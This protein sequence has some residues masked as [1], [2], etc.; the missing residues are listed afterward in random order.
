MKFTL[1][2]LF[3]HIDTSCS[4]D[5]IVEKLPTLG[6]EVEDVCDCAKKFAGIFVGR[7]V[8]CKKH[9]NADKLSLC[10]VDV[11]GRNGD[12]L[13]QIVCGATN[14]RCGLTVAVALPGTIIPVTGAKLKSGKIRGIESEAMMCSVYELQMGID[15]DGIIELDDSF[16]IGTPFA[17]AM[18][19]SDIVFDVSITPNRADCCCVRGIARMLAA[20]GLGT[21]KDIKI[22]QC[23]ESEETNVTVNIETEKCHYFSYKA[24]YGIQD[25]KTPGYIARRLSAIGQKVI[26][27]PVDI[28]NY[29]CLD[30]GQPMHMFDLDKL[31]DNFIVRESHNAEEI[32]ALNGCHLTIPDEGII[33]G[34]K[35]DAFSVA[36]IIGGVQTA[37]SDT[38]KNVLIESAHFDRIAISL[39]AQKMRIQTDSSYRN[40]RGVD[41]E[42]VD[43]AMQYAS[44]LLGTCCDCKFGQTKSIGQLPDN[45][46]NIVVHYDRFVK[47][48][49][50]TQKEWQ[51]IAGVVEKLDIKVTEFNDKE[52]HVV[53]PS[54]R[55]DLNIE[56]DIIEE[57]MIMFGYDAIVP[58]DLP[59]TE[60]L[61]DKRCSTDII[62]DT[63][64]ANGVN[65]IKTFSFIDEDTCKIFEPDIAKHVV[66][67][68]PLTNEFAVMRPNLISSILRVLKNN[69]D[70][71][72][73]D[74]RLF[75]IGKRFYKLD[76]EII[77][78]NTLLIV[79]MGSN[80]ERIWSE[81]QR[82]VDVFDIKSIVERL[83]SALNIQNY[84]IE[85]GGAQHFHPG[86]VGK[87]VIRRNDCLVEFGELH[88]EI[89]NKLDIHTPV[90]FAEMDLELIKSL[91]NDCIK[92]PCK[93]P[94][95]QPVIRDFSFIVNNNVTSADIV[96]SIKK[97]H[98]DL[99]EN[100]NI[101]DVYNID[102]DKKAV[103]VEVIMQ[104]KKSTLTEQQI[105]D[106]SEKIISY[107][108]KNCSATLRT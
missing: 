21:L 60:P 34:T 106:A 63:L 105:N 58:E 36:G 35:N 74:C 33:V 26:S 80:H 53:T 50:L 16:K 14:V 11:G 15:H 69:Y 40:M 9:P 49:G 93:N 19:M 108:S 77:E 103:G 51:V 29:I 38:T 86:R 90:V 2:W 41:P 32:D 98:I 97:T 95:Y 107:V 92:V 52:M 68:A 72:R 61:A 24:V 22:E 44:S 5:E 47:L 46:K 37:V 8:E 73:K 10:M 57:F 88:P 102:D 78:S 6:I 7:I 48:T 64:I 27:A 84:R 45:T 79:L 54:F 101:F 87:Y 89:L 71:K 96:N 12:K 59:N 42:M 81:K 67:K 56:E 1:D 85:N 62:T 91:Q 55:F 99:I 17:E 82:D 13:L 100:I 43:F 30:I 83:L 18:N 39:S 70:N 31:P 104:P 65:E 75:E 66:L 25:A 23:Q 76:N 3:D 20:A 28:A 94:V 4:V